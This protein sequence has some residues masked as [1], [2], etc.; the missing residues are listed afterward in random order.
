MRNDPVCDDGSGYGGRSVSSVVSPILTRVSNAGVRNDGIG[1]SFEASNA[2]GYQR[3]TSLREH[4]GACRSRHRRRALKQPKIR[5][6][7]VIV[8]S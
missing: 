8:A 6:A 7:I 1:R 4:F 5:S 3:C 2:I